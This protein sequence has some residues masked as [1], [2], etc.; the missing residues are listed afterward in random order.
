[1]REQELKV[2]RDERWGWDSPA[3]LEEGAVPTLEVKSSTTTW[4]PVLTAQR[5][6]VEVL[7][8]AEGGDVLTASAAPPVG[9]YSTG[10]AGEAWLIAGDGQVLEVRVQRVAGTSIYLAK[11]IPR[12]V[13]ITDALRGRVQWRRW[14]TTF[15]AEQEDETPGPTAEAGHL[16]WR[17]SYSQIAPGGGVA[18][19]Y[20]QDI[21]Q[22]AKR[23]FWPGVTAAQIRRKIPAANFREPRSV[24]LDGIIEH[25]L[26]ELVAHIESK[27]PRS[28]DVTAIENA[29]DFAGPHVEL[30]RA[31]LPKVD[32]DSGEVYRKRALDWAD[33]L[34]VRVLKDL[35]NNGVPNPP[36]RSNRRHQGFDGG[37]F[38][39]SRRFARNM[40]R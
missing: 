20:D 15:V 21:V 39:T 14:S 4:A 24:T 8:I 1:M 18:D 35:N 16:S 7:A 17:V 38:P 12:P 29:R 28:E 31:M 10:E 32:V 34:L 13:V 37:G 5:P 23:R 6:E 3:P 33:K 40:N 2:G 36:P 22:V 9:E 27:L 11:P 26:E 19:G 25:A 30:V